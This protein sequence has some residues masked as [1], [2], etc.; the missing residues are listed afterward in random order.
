MRCVGWWDKTDNGHGRGGGGFSVLVLCVDYPLPAA[1]IVRVDFTVRRAVLF[2]DEDV[3]A[4]Q[5]GRG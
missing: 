1:R 2:M 3:P 4:D 5:E